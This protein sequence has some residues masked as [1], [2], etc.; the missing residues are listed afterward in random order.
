[1][2]LPAPWGALDEPSFLR[3]RLL[4]PTGPSSAPPSR[5]AE[6]RTVVGATLEVPRVAPYGRPG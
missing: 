2:G 6:H 3:D 1:M 5:R 4:T